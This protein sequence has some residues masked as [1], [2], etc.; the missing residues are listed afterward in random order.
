MA[1]K[2]MQP[3][4][5]TGLNDVRIKLTRERLARIL[6]I[7][8][9]CGG[10]LAI[11]EVVCR[12]G[13]MAWE[14]EQAAA[15]GWLQIETRKP[16]I[17][18]PSRIVRIVSGSTSAKL[19]PCRSEIERPISTRH[20]LF[21]LNSIQCAKHG[22]RGLMPLPPMVD[23]YQ[24]VFAH[25]RKRR[26]ATASASRLLRHP[27]VCAARRWW[28]AQIRQEIPAGEPMPRTAGGIRRALALVN[29]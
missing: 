21:A 17:G 29:S 20:F 22:R 12:H 10:A 7:L 25:A 16:R 23:A 19:P 24:R 3:P 5:L 15:L 2:T 28:Q 4:C 14:V 8:G 11:R 13:V 18:R 26:A 27:D 9:R 6:C 1:L